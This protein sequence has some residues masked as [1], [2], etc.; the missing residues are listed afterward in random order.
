VRTE[1]VDAIYTSPLGRARTTAEIIVAA[2]GLAVH[3]VDA[4]SEVD[5]GDFSG[6]TNAEVAR[7]APD[8]KRDK[9][10]WRFPT[11]RATP[12]PTGGHRRHCGQSPRT[13][14]GR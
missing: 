7:R 2:S 14:R 6:L 13:R 4:L 1:D 10:T 8:R 3:V 5:H 12:T 9:Y 11:A